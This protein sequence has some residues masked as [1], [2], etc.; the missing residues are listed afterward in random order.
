[1]A[2]LLAGV[3]LQAAARVQAAAAA[4]AAAAGDGGGLAAVKPRAA[5]LPPPMIP[6]NADVPTT[7]C[8]MQVCRDVG[9]LPLLAG[10]LA[11]YRLPC[12]DYTALSVAFA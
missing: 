9:W 2:E 1:M 4:A 5:E 7:L 11:G 12:R 8:A 6:G 3:V 10:M